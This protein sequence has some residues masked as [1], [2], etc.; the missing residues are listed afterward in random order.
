VR[1]VRPLGRIGGMIA[2]LVGAVVLVGAPAASAHPLGNFTVNRY[3]GF[4]LRP[5]HVQITYVIDMAEIPTFEAMPQIDSNGDGTAGEAEKQAWADRTAP[6]VLAKLTLT[7][8][9]QRVPLSVVT[10]SMRFRPGQAG[11]PILYFKAEF[12]GVV[13]PSGSMQYRDQNF[14]GRIGWKEITARSEAGVAIFASSVR[15]AS[16]SDE[17][18]SYPVD[19]LSS[20]LDERQ[21]A[22]SFQPGRPAPIPQERVGGARTTG[23]P[24]ASG[25]SFAALVEWKLTPLVLAASLLLALLF[26]ALHALGPGH[27]KTITAA[28]LVGAG[29]RRRQAL[30]IGVAVSIMH[31]VSV[32]A[33]GL[34]AL[35]L[36]R[37]FPADRVYPWLTLVTGLVALGLGTGLAIVRLQARRNGLDPWHGHAH[38]LDASHEDGALPGGGAETLD[39]GFGPQGREHGHEHGDGWH[40]HEEQQSSGV[41]VLEREPTSGPDHPVG[42]VR[43]VPR[44]P[45]SGRGLM[46]L[47]VA[48]GILPSPTALVVLTGAI[49]AHRVAYGLGLIAAFS[50]GLAA[51][52]MGVGMVAIRL[53]SAVSARLTSKVA[54]LIPIVSALVIVGFG[55]FFAS[56]GITQLT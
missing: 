16:I 33:L 8:S 50:M 51:A 6:Q 9:G 22:F 4:D 31:T 2:V 36:A 28:Y 21:A 41:M 7:V 15:G 29:A 14:G 56:R 44:K 40:A 54:G 13:P 24:I 5:G 37:S 42:P 3:S 52:L 48:G 49:Y 34:V 46:A 11:L 38:P 12:A 39:P 47:A 27:G 20:P 43:M 23:A 53:R 17:L 55:V 32:L 45:I 19:L 10:D 25:R 26:G 30:L 35:V 1:I 18:Q